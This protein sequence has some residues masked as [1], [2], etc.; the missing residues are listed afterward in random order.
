MEFDQ[1]SEPE[2]G[3]KKK[4]REREKETEREKVGLLS[5]LICS[6]YN[7]VDQFIEIT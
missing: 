7:I 5:L 3:Q 4:M 2:E 6:S 1:N